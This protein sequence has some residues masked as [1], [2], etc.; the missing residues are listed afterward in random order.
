MQRTEYKKADLKHLVLITGMFTAIIC[1]LIIILLS[2]KHRLIDFR[3]E[4]I[5][6]YD[7]RFE[8]DTPGKSEIVSVNYDSGSLSFSYIL[9]PGF[10]YPYAGVSILFG[11]S[12][13]GYLDCSAFD[14]LGIRISSSQLS[15]CKIYLKVFDDKVSRPNDPIS[16]RYLKKELVLNRF[17]STVSIP[18]SEFITPDW[19]FQKNNITLKDVSPLDFSKVTSLQI[20]SGPTAKTG[21]SDT[22][23]V[24][25]IRFIRRASRYVISLC[26]ILSATLFV[27]IL[28]LIYRNFRPAKNDPVIIPYE[29]KEL[30]NYRDIDAQRIA[31][32]I[33]EH[34]S[35][36]ELSVL[37]MAKNLG[38]SQK[39][40]VK[41]MKEVFRLS[42][43]QYLL[44]IR[45]HE[46]KR[47]LLQTDRP[48]T[49]VALTVGFNT[50]SHFNRVF[51]AAAGV[52]PKEFRNNRNVGD[53]QPETPV[54]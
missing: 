15:D 13:A 29:K 2:R 21:I 30:I 12:T 27:Y 37:T 44:K 25:E 19:W 48:V 23:T 5:I 9:R 6:A 36:P 45:I 51:K 1:C 28:F 24:S 31:S 17:P 34:F 16:E 49:D 3:Q 4:K 20:E 52:S 46:A 38:L 50:I 40:V 26:L 47:L 14:L 11:D 43:K 32:Y 53:R 39:K 54:R 35:D 42:F 7:D 33:A 8:K 22:I 41:V 18:F 10:A